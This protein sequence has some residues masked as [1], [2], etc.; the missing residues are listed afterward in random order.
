[1]R[2]LLIL[3]LL[4]P[5]SLKADLGG[6]PKAIQMARQI[7]ESIGGNH[8]WRNARSMYVVEKSRSLKGDGIIG[9]FHRDLT[10]PRERYSLNSRN[11]TRIEFWWDERGVSQLVDGTSNKSNLPE[12]IHALVMDYWHGEIYVMLH[13]LASEDPKLKLLANED[14]SFTAFEGERRLGTFWV[15]AQ[16]ELYRWRHDDGTEYIYGPLKKFGNIYFPDW[17]TQ[18]DGSWS[19]YYIEVRL[20]DSPPKVDFT[21]HRP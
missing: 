9:E 10:V 12:D 18:V 21:P 5:I 16:G 17:G 6:D 15:N 11:G 3:M 13:R 2:T 14:S 20:S 4:F 1:M 19:F 7:I 8:V